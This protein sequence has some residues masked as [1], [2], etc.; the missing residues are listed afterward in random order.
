VLSAGPAAGAPATGAATPDPAGAGTPEIPPGSTI[1]EV[2]VV[3]RNIFDLERPG[4]NKALFRL[5]DRLHRTT[6]PEVV[7]RQLLFKSGDPYSPAALAESARLLRANRYLYEVEIRPFPAAGN[8]VDVVVSTRDVWTLEGGF[9]FRRAGGANTTRFEVSDTNLLGTGKAFTLQHSTSIDRTSNLASYVDPSLRGSRG[10]LELSFVDS[11][12]GRFD[13]VDLERPFYSLDTRWATGIE[14]S[15]DDR[16]D[17]LYAHSHVF[18]RFR[19]RQDFFQVYGGLSP[20]LAGGA[21]RRW[22]LGFTYERDRFSPAAGLA[23]PSPLPPDR[24]LSY[25]W[26]DFEYVE[27]GFIVERDLDRIQRSE[28]LNV[29]S[30]FHALLGGSSTAFGAGADRLIFASAGSTGWHPAPRQLLLAAAGVSARWG[31]QSGAENGIA[32]GRLRYYARDFGDHVFLAALRGDLARRLDPENQ[33][34]LGGDTGLRGYPLR[35]Q[36]GDRR[37]LVTLEQRF[38]SDREYFHLMHAGAAVFFDAGRA[39]FPDSASPSALDRRV[40]KDVGVGLRLGSSRS[41]RGSMVHLDLAFPLDRDRSIK[42][43][44]WL[45]SSSET[46]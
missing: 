24:T 37:F 26:I 5:A 15:Q 12:D 20:G 14:A 41:A 43:V 28:D 17:S 27:N 2:R 22:R 46:F 40:L 33:I 31:R 7:E 30:Q 8:K 25:P 44:Q 29:G 1:G 10:R 16:V 34:L 42:S 32:S 19:Q 11:S 35:L 4:E 23:P 18:D 21:T 9:G 13:R 38:F 3:T 36:S 45:V 6:R 39:W